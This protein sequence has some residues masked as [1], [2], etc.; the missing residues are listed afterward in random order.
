[1]MCKWIIVRICVFLV[2]FSGVLSEIYD[3][4]HLEDENQQDVR[5]SYSKVMD[6]TIPSVLPSVDSTSSTAMKHTVQ[7]QD[8]QARQLHQWSAGMY[9]KPKSRVARPSKGKRTQFQ[10]NKTSSMLMTMTK[11]MMYENYKGKGSTASMTTSNVKTSKMSRHKRDSSSSKYK[12]NS[13]VIGKGCIQM[14]N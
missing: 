1:M 13:K 11:A 5:G 14:A 3:A 6:K 9:L 10:A 4:M 8:Q 7:E 12:M 2:L